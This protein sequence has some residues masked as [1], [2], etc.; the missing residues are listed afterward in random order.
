MSILWVYIQ[1]S[2]NV[3]D[4]SWGKFPPSSGFINSISDARPRSL[5]SQ[6]LPNCVALILFWGLIESPAAPLLYTSCTT[7]LEKQEYSYNAHC[8]SLEH[9]LKC[10][11]SFGPRIESG[12]WWA[13]LGPTKSSSSL[14]P[15]SWK[16]NDIL[17]WQTPTFNC[18]GYIIFLLLPVMKT[19]W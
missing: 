19:S 5:W 1:Y 18:A 14:L 8:E 15:Q 7:I 16:K 9:I 6:F 2:L 10:A 4:V 3:D 13:P 17:N 12:V 11:M